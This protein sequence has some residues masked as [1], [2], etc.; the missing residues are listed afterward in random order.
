MTNIEKIQKFIAEN[1]TLLDEGR[2]TKF[3][4]LLRNYAFIGDVSYML[5]KSDIDIFSQPNGLNSIPTKYMYDCNQLTEF[6]LPDH[7]ISRINDNAFMNCKNLEV[8]DLICNESLHSIGA[9]AF[10][11]C[12]N[13]KRLKLPKSLSVISMS[14]FLDCE[15]IE[16]I[17][18]TGTKED[19]KSKYSQYT[20]LLIRLKPGCK[21]IC[22]D[23]EYTIKRIE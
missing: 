14:A 10:S 3:Y 2:W 17:E 12:I 23:G 18:Y 16:L 6:I 1:Q 21:I 22:S 4:A 19:W 13:L 8:V 5:L 11:N 7:Y 15:N 20:G 9:A